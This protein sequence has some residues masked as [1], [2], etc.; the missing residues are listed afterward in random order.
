[1][2]NSEVTLNFKTLS[3]KQFQLTF[4]ASETVRNDHLDFGSDVTCRRNEII[5][6]DYFQNFHD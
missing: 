6:A 1:M 5:I 4:N 3:K 2:G